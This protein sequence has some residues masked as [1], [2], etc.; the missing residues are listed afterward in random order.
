MS[1]PEIQ[2]MVELC[3]TSLKTIEVRDA[4]LKRAWGII[5]NAY[6]GDWDLASDASGWKKAAEKWE[7]EYFRAMPPSIKGSEKCD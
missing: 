2:L 1:F 6:G 5:A 7:D 3:E 4:L